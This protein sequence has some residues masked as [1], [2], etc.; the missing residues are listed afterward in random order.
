MYPFVLC[1]FARHVVLSALSCLRTEKRRQ[2]VNRFSMSDMTF[3]SKI[4]ER[5]RK[6]RKSVSENPPLIPND[7]SDLFGAAFHDTRTS[8]GSTNECRFPDENVSRGEMIRQ[9][10]IFRLPFRFVIRDDEDTSYDHR[11]IKAPIIMPYPCFPV[12]RSATYP[13]RCSVVLFR[14]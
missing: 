8:T 7:A 13:L 4:L 5:Q 3:A 10:S 11:G 12:H 1:S 6:Q 2:L 14:P 9:G